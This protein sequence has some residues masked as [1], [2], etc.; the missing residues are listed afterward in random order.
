MAVDCLLNNDPLIGRG[1]T[2]A[3]AR[4]IRTA[5]VRAAGRTSTHS[6]FQQKEQ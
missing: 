6:I 2:P 4:P 1:L 5:R 3:G